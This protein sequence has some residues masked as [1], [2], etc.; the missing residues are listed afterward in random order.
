MKNKVIEPVIE[1]ETNKLE[2]HSSFGHQQMRHFCLPIY[3][4][5]KLTLFTEHLEQSLLAWLGLL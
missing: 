5:A 1:Y 2:F 3:A 4:N